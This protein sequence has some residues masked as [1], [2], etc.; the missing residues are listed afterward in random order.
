MALQVIGAGFGRTGTLS[1]KQALDELGLGPTYH[2]E[3][4]VRRPSH[5]AS[6]SSS[7]SHE[8][9]VAAPPRGEE[10]AVRLAR[11]RARHWGQLDARLRIWQ[12]RSRRQVASPA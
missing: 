9:V 12:A 4:V 5:V 11:M 3:E 8:D 1:L 10:T 2:M 6:C 7:L